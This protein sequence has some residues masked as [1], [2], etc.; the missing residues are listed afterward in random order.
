MLL[1]GTHPRTLDDKK[2][3]ALADARANALQIDFAKTPPTK[4]AFFGIRTFRDYDLAELADYIDWTP[5]FQTWELKGR[6]PA[7]SP[8]SSSTYSSFFSA[9]HPS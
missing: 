2:R 1:T 9:G 5:F 3:L 6:F 4:P 7:I 8:I